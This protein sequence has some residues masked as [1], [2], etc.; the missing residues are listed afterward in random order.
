MPHVVTEKCLGEVYAAC[1]E[2]CPVEAFHPGEYK[3]Q[4]FMVIDPD[5]CIDCGVC[6]PECPIG[7]IVGSVDDSPEWAKVNA[8]LSPVF[9]SNPKA[10]PRDQK[11]APHKPENKL[12]K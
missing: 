6:L 3:G 4:P 11:E 1:V 5:L 10:T 2:G 12:V 8:E 9:K 7:A